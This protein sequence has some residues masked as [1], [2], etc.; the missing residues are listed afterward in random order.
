MRNF[1]SNRS[2]LV[3]KFRAQR[4]ARLTSLLREREKSRTVDISIS[5]LILTRNYVVLPCETRVKLRRSVYSVRGYKYDSSGAY[6][7]DG[8]FCVRD[9]HLV[10]HVKQ[11]SSSSS[12]FA[13]VIAPSTQPATWRVAR[14]RNLQWRRHA[15]IFMASFGKRE[16]YDV[17]L[18]L[19]RRL[20]YNSFV[21]QREKTHQDKI[22]S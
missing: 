5:V 3:E 9:A 19:N 15:S 1:D 13:V 16:L 6:Y 22:I 17:F 8:C 21:T 14:I 20:E 7:P 12:S 18:N 10:C 4:N 11:K 2:S